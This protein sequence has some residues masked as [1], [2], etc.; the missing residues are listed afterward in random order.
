[1]RLFVLRRIALRG[2]YTLLL[3]CK[4]PFKLRIGKLGQTKVEKGYYL[5]TGSALGTGA[6]SL[7]QRIAR[8]RRRNKRM[9]WHVDYLTACREIAVIT[10]ICLEGNKRLEC[11]I[12]QEILSRLDGKPIIRRAGASDCKCSGHLLSVKLPDSRVILTRLKKI[13]SIHGEP[14]FL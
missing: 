14:S 5:Y 2:T 3:A 10:V 13:Y 9:K 6:V 11:Q 12:N 7:E 1:M 8:H 4:R